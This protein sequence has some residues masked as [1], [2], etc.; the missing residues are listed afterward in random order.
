MEGKE[1]KLLVP[2]VSADLVRVY[3]AR[4]KRGEVS[5]TTSP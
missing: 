4:D 2:I 1:A 3:Y 5:E